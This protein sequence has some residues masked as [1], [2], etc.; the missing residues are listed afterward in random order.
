MEGGG[1]PRP[2]QPASASRFWPMETGGTLIP[3]IGA[4]FWL[5][6]QHDIPCWKTRVFSSELARSDAPLRTVL[7]RNRRTRSNRAQREISLTSVRTPHL[8]ATCDVWRNGPW[9]MP[10]GWRRLLGN[11]VLWRI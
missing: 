3:G 7:V 2:L 6:E 5:S 9:K 11:G 1:A 8:Y 10:D 4:H